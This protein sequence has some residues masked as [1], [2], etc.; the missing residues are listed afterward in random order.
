[1][2][3]SGPVV[4]GVAQ[5]TSLGDALFFVALMWQVAQVGAAE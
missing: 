5:A 2:D 1:M 4:P 3:I